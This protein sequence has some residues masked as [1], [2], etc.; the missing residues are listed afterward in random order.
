MKI[1]LSKSQ[2]EEMGKKAGWIKTAGEDWMVNETY[3]KQ[4]TDEL[5]KRGDEVVSSDSN[6][7]VVNHKIDGKVIKGLMIRVWEGS[8]EG[9][10]ILNMFN[11]STNQ[12]LGMVDGQTALEAIDNMDKQLMMIVSAINER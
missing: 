8:Y 7:A 11:A 4:I 5:I 6:K 9:W 3:T 10:F 2:W 1:K 12:M